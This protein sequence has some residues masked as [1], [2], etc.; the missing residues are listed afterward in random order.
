MIGRSL[1]PRQIKTAIDL[2]IGGTIGYY[3]RA[4][5][6]TWEHCNEIEEAR[7]QMLNQRELCA[8]T[9]RAAVYIST[10]AGGLAHQHAYQ[11][12]S[13]AFIDQIHRALNGG[14]GEPAREAITERIATTCARMGCK[15]PPLTWL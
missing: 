13:A 15:G 11:W 7:L 9:P 3:A 6:M 8:K 14:C 2:S 10:E 1:G 12:A 5:P 4:T